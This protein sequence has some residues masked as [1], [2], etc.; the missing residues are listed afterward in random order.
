M[1][2]PEHGHY[3]HVCLPCLGDTI[4]GEAIED[5]VAMERARIVAWLRSGIIP[6]GTDPLAYLAKAIERG[7]H[8]KEGGE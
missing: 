5:G 7:D 1:K 2:C 3:D 8:L 6:I 4:R